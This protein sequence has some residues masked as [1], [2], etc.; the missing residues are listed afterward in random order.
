MAVNVSLTDAATDLSE[1][2]LRAL[3]LGASWY[4]NY[5]RRIIA[6]QADDRSAAATIRREEFE[7]LRSGLRKLGIRLRPAGVD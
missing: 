2:E 4:F 3:A 7:E 5:H 6:D 1:T